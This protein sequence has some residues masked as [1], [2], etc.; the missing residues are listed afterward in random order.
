MDRFST[1]KLLYKREKLSFQSY[2]LSSSVSI[3][4]GYLGIKKVKFLTEAR[5]FVI[6]SAQ[7]IL[8]IFD[9]DI[10]IIHSPKATL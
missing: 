5:G 7:H 6:I 9:L 8:E 3:P 10:S 2:N 1:D 4:M